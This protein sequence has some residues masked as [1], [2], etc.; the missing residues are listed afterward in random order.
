MSSFCRYHDAADE[1][2][3]NDPVIVFT[4]SDGN[5]SSNSSLS[6][7]IST[8]DDHPTL[9]SVN[10]SGHYRYTEGNPPTTLDGILLDDRDSINSDVVVNS[11]TIEVVDGDNN[12]NLDTSFIVP[13]MTVSNINIVT[14]RTLC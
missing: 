7:S 13:N 5:F 14:S 8:I 4:I 3:S 11:V 9:V 2:D 6:L 12:E 10:G 1:P